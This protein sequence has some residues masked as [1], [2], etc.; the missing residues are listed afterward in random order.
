MLGVRFPAVFRHSVGGVSEINV[1]CDI[2]TDKFGLEYWLFS[3]DSAV[4]KK[5][6]LMQIVY[7]PSKRLQRRII[8]S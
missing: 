4:A 1:S 3:D 7:G 6:D 5:G 8:G 2:Y